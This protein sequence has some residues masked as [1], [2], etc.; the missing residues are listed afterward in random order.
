MNNKLSERGKQ[1]FTDDIQTNLGI[2]SC[3]DWKRSI[4]SY[5]VYVG[6]I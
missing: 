6:E 4:M 5:D 2:G 3:F 1:I